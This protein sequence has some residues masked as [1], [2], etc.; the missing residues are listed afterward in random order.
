MIMVMP[1]HDFPPA[2]P[3]ITPGHDPYAFIT[4]PGTPAKKPKLPLPQGNSTGQRVLIVALAVV[5]LIIIA[6]VVMTILG[7]ASKQAVNNMVLAAQQQEELRRISTIGVKDAR[8]TP[9]KNLAATTLYT[10]ESD[11]PKLHAI[12]NKETKLEKAILAQ[13]K[14]EATTTILAE[15]KQT[16]RFDEVFTELLKKEM[17][18]YQSTLK[19]VHDSA[20]KKNKPTLA[21]QYRNIG[22]L[23]GE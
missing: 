21:E 7:S 10:L 13:G 2:P 15:A 12:V 9:T 3:P 22:L 18:E 8:T 23:I 16:N 4:N 1:P 20:N 14:D 19:K 11:K 5:F 6:S 17:R